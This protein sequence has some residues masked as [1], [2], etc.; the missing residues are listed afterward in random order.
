MADNYNQALLFLDDSAYLIFIENMDQKFRVITKHPH[1]LQQ[2]ARFLT[3]IDSLSTRNFTYT[4]GQKNHIQEPNFKLIM[5]S[6]FDGLVD[7]STKYMASYI[8][9]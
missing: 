3:F 2:G 7:L 4:K 6:D 5:N 1:Y 9:I 8:C